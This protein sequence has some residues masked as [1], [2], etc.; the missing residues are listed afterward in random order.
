[1]GSLVPGLSFVYVRASLAHRLA[2][3]LSEECV[4]I[5]FS[6]PKTMSVNWEALPYYLSHYA[7]RLFFYTLYHI[8]LNYNRMVEFK[9]SLLCACMW[10]D[11]ATAGF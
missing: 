10:N 4:I 8:S 5:Y 7:A 2:A 11:E 9:T 6:L 1:M 3:C